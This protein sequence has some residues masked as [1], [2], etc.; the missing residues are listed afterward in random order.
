VLRRCLG[1]SLALLHPFM[2]FL[3][4]EIWEKLTARPGTLVVTPYPAGTGRRSD[5]EAEAAVEAS[6]AVVTRVRTYR[7]ERGAKPTEPVALSIDPASPGRAVMPQLMTLAPLI[8]HLGRL[9]ELRFAPAAAG[10]FQDVVAGLAVGLSL[11][12]GDAP[13]ATARIEKDLAAADSEIAELKAKLENASY[14]EKAPP[15]V[16]EKTRRRLHEL[17]EKRAALA[18]SRP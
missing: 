9:S 15:A 13:G 8:E 7:T 14:R 3:T 16:V 17:E 12:G 4:E 10:T 5:P 11:P 2:P 6:R 18:G 1:D